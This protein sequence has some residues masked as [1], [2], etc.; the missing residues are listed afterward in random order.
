M[1][2]VAL[3]PMKANSQRIPGK[4]FKAFCGKPLFR[5]V[6]DTLLSVDQ[7]EQTIINSDALEELKNCGLTSND[8]VLVQR[9]AN[10]LSGDEVSMNKIIEADISNNA[11]DVY[12]M[13]HTTNPF[14]SVGTIRQAFNSYY[15]GLSEGYDSLFSVDRVQMRFFNKEAKPLNHDP[16]NL[17]QTQDLEPWFAE[18]SNFYIFSGESFKAANARIGLKPKMFVSSRLESVDIDTPDDWA[19]AEALGNSNYFKR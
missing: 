13:T 3:L 6:L 1:K 7:I 16:D 17:I 11:A 2:V 19:F 4:N 9:R 10:E 5:W 14:L 8:R 12:F 18:N 15:E